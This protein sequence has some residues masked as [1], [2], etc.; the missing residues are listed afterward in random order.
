MGSAIINVAHEPRNSRP[1]HLT[2]GDARYRQS[3]IIITAPSMA[4][5]ELCCAHAICEYAQIAKCAA[6]F[7]YR[8]WIRVKLGL[9]LGI[10][11]PL[12]SGFGQKFANCARAILKLSSAFFTHA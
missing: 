4:H 8:V 7:G 1:K 3:L 12:V 6:Q 9:Q 5:S 2:T 10:G 11:L